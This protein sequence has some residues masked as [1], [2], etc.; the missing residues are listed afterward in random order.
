MTGSGIFLLPAAL[1]IF[2]GISIFGWLFT[3]AGAVF[4]ALVFSRL[5]RL[6]TK[7]GGPFTYAREGFGNLAG[8]M[9][10]WGYWI[11][12]WCGNAA[13]SVAGVGYL[14]FFIPV[15]KENQ[16]L[17]ALTAVSAIWLFTYINT[18][19]IREVGKVQLVTTALK[20]LPLIIFGTIGFLYFEPGHFSP[21]NLSSKPAF[22]AVTATAALTLWSF[23]G[24]ES[25]TIPSDQVKDPAKTISRA[26]IT[27]I[28]LAALLYITSTVGVMGIIPPAELQQSAAP[29]ADAAMI[30]WGPLPSGLIAAG[31]AIACFGALNGWILLQGQIPMAAAR[32][33]LFPPVFMK[34]SRRGV[35]VPGILI[36]SIL[37]TILVGFNYSRGLVNMFA[38]IIKLATLSCLL[39]YLF[40]SLS[41]LMLY[42]RK[43][44]DFNKKRLF[45]ASAIGVP[46]FIYSMWAI[47]GLEHEIILYGAILLAAGIPF[48][49]YILYSSGK[50]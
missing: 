4:L 44:K 34:I 21:F 10:A 49:Y 27:G 32:D 8:F 7:T 39:P 17:S 47:T 18:W 16:I 11:S 26:T 3:V 12:I 38:F 6:I 45:S 14:S 20:I 35:P 40:S 42:L 33:R 1:A 19:S 23:L 43:R 50:S 5:S 13:I 29:F 25:A 31:A 22:E 48:Y 30:N 41:E 37:A 2:G 36:A 9:V 46:A 24:L 28:F 15:L